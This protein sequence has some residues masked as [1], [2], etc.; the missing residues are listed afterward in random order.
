M[1]AITSISSL[2]TSEVAPDSAQQTAP[3]TQE[4]PTASEEALRFIDSIVPEDD[5]K[6]LMFDDN[7]VTSSDTGKELGEFSVSVEPTNYKHQACFLIH[8][9]S[10][11][12]ID[13][14]PCGTSITAYVAQN[15][16]TLE[17]QHHEYVKLENCPLDRKTFI[18]K[19]EDGIVVNRVITQGEDIQRSSKTI[20]LEQM[21]GFISEGSN[22][23]LHRLLIEKDVPDNLEM[24]SFDSDCNLCSAVYRPLEDRTQTV[25]G[26]E[27]RVFGVERTIN[28]VADLPT[29]WQSYFIQD[30]HLS[31]RV[32]VGSPVTMKLTKVPQLIERDEEPP[33]PTFEKRPLNWEEDMQMYSKFLDRKNE[34]KGDHSSYIRQHPELKAL[35]ADF[36]QFLLLR[37]PDDVIAFSAEYFA[38][39][40]ATMPSP[41]PYLASN[42]PTPFPA[43]RTN[44][45]IDQL[46]A[47]TR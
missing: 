47:P 13:G 23:L 6:Y 10:H 36:L 3:V 26:T 32:Q 24:L 43:S 4:I 5:Y 37:K 45:K 42:A 25:D 33:K 2:S 28:S 7:L 8:A 9:N 1:S 11:G 39:F 18:V 38:S 40:A 19:Q 31:S 14:V 21:K 16:E 29:T 46:R 30:G 41:T 12:A 34:L 35:L 44:T 15:L 17:Q 27:I 20:P 22:L